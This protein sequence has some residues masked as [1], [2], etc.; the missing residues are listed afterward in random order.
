MLI[1][2]D[3]QLDAFSAASIGNFEVRMVEYLETEYPTRAESLG[4][5]GLAELVRQG[6][7]SAATHELRSAGAIAIWIEL[8]LQF[9][10]DLK[11]SPERAWAGRILAHPRL[12]DH[13]KLE[14]IRER[15]TAG[16]AGRPIV[17]ATIAG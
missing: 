9:G 7:Q 1:V 17:R 16:T 2:R 4:V 8:I 11:L 5:A 3:A 10:E 14:V 12:P 6:I 13:I 15:L